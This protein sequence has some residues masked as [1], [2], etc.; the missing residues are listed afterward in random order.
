MLRS[1]QIRPY[2]PPLKLVPPRGSALWEILRLGFP[3]GLTFFLEIGVFSVIGLL[4]STMGNNAMAAHQIAYNVWDV[5][6]MPLISVGSAMAT[7]VGHAIGAGDEPRVM[8]A[9]KTGT[10]LTMLVGVGCTAF[11]IAI[12]EQIISAYTT[13]H[14][15]HA[16]AVSLIR[17]VA[18]FIIIDSVQVAAAF[19]LRAFKDTRYPFV[20]MCLSYWLLAL[21]L[22]YWLGMEVADNPADGTAAFWTS[23]IAGICVCS[24]LV[25]WRLYQKLRQP[26]WTVKAAKE[27]EALPD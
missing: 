13:E 9:V 14:A 23:L 2:L 8:L 10:A 24:V 22:G 19:C 1:D 7:R 4:I 26:G 3:I 18:L 6:Y 17:L 16:I 15:I 27:A 12:P 25:S 5:V 11:L 20:V 21:P